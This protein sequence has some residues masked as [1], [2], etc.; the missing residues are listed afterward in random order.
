M[1]YERGRQSRQTSTFMLDADVRAF[2]EI[3]V[4]GISGI[5]CWTIDSLKP[6]A[7]VTIHR[8]L[9][10]ALTDDGQAFLRLTE[11]GVV[12][13][14]RLQYISTDMV[15]A[16]WSGPRVSQDTPDA[17]IRAGRL[18]Y[19]WFPGRELDPIRARFSD[20][21]AIAWKALHAVTAAHLLQIDGKPA[22][23]ARIGFATKRWVVNHPGQQ[24]VASSTCLRLQ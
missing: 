1:P 19:L 10:E 2:D 20:L 18:S 9:R 13:G 16:S 17:F 12:I 4:P 5:A 6:E 3:L 22:R 23:S 21:V 15:A 24:L 14:P 8:S 7:V 11:D